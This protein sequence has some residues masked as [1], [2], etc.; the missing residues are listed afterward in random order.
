MGAI[1]KFRF[2]HRDASRL[3]AK[4]LERKQHVY[5]NLHASEEL[6]LEIKQ[7]GWRQNGALVGKLKQ[8]L[9]SLRFYLNKSSILFNNIVWCLW[10]RVCL[11]FSFHWW[12]APRS[13]RWPHSSWSVSQQNPTKS[14]WGIA[15]SLPANIRDRFAETRWP[16]PSCPVKF[17]PF[18]ITAECSCLISPTYHQGLAV[19]ISRN[20]PHY[21]PS[22]LESE[23]LT[24][25]NLL[26]GLF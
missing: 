18:S 12:H 21:A 17:P 7:I 26:V 19:S 14:S 2:W 3:D 10:F 15:A 6:I 25:I 4:R 23:L 16:S 5:H 20:L 13:S 1:L 24:M 22:D 11:I 8:P 9:I